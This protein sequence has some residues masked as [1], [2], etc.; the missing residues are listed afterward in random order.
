MIDC[1]IRR[2]GRY[3]HSEQNIQT[4][5]YQCISFVVSGLRCFRMGSIP[6]C[7]PP[8]FFCFWPAQVPLTF[9]FGPDRENWAIILEAPQL[10]LLPQRQVVEIAHHDGIITIPAFLP[11]PQERVAGWQWELQRMQ[12]ALQNP[13]PQ[14]TLRANLGVMNILRYALDRQADAP[15]ATPAQQ[16]KRLIDL[17]E[18]FLESLAAL[19]KQCGYSVDHLRVLFTQEYQMSPVHYRNRRRMSLA[20]ELIANSRLSVK[21]IADRLGFQYVSHFSSAFRDE[22]NIPPSA[23]IK[24]FRHAIGNSTKIEGEKEENFQAKKG[25]ISGSREVQ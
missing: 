14:N 6:D 17:D 3:H 5:D 25:E 1:T 2:I 16:L 7:P 13:T 18:H 9:A 15:D 4:N 21:E 19:S 10:H 11:V 8:P 23:G 22:F 20:M 12:E 24:R